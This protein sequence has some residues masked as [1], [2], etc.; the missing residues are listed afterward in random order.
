[1][2][3]EII[4]NVPRSP[5]TAVFDRAT[6]LRSCGHDLVDLSIGE[7]DFDTPDHI[8][9]A[10]IEAINT[11]VTRYTAADGT[12][13]LKDAV[14]RKF[15][16][17]NQLVFDRSQVVIASGAKPL[18]ASAMQVVLN[19]GDKIILSTPAWTSHVGMAQVCAA[20]PVFLETRESE[21]YRIDAHRLEAAITPDTKLL[22]LCSPGN[23]TGAVASTEELGTVAEVL[24]RHPHVNVIS[25]D[26]Y[27]HIVFSPAKFATL[28]QVAPD[29]A[30][31]VLTVNGL[32]KAYAMTGWRIGYAGGPDWWTSG[33]RVLFSQTSG[34]PCSISQAAAV[35]ALDGPQEFLEERCHVYRR[36][37]DRA[38]SEL[39]KVPGLKAQAPEGAFFLYVDCGKYIGKRAPNGSLITSSTDLAEHLL[40][41]GVVTVPGA[42]F[43]ADP[44]LRLS[45]ATSEESIAEGIRRIGV[46]C[47]QLE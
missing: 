16:R 27:E 10:G 45:V 11:G 40:A 4:R 22:L 17:D 31:R 41:A 46:G 13:A 43:Y 44:F 21:A 28:A 14:R 2:L 47:R 33:L 32:S 29:L 34:G 18:I 25:D 35:A 24:R 38:L 36:R 9:A 19:P 37:R 1:M 39:S 30:D 8:R 12:A 23:P 7:P 15:S 20:D 6:E 5:I 42:A 3:S 26:L